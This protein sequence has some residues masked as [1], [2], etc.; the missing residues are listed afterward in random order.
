MKT[1]KAIINIGVNEGYNHNNESNIDFPSY[2]QKFSEDNF[3][4]IGEYIPFVIYPVKT[5]YRKEW[6]CPD[7]G[8]DTYI[9]TATANPKF[10]KDVKLWK[11]HLI[12][13][14][15]RLKKE[16]KQSTVSVEFHDV[17]FAYLDNNGVYW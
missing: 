13:Y 3:E 8:E 14:V 15:N 11:L 16:L 7:N 9:L 6:G 2:I 1:L 5:V 12:E 4:S 10:V 17:D